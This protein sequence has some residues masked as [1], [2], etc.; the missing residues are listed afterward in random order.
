M[1]EKNHNNTIRRSPAKILQEQETD[2]ESQKT[3]RGTNPESK[4]E[5][6][7]N[8]SLVLSGCISLPLFEYEQR[9]ET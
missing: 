2:R 6:S 3:E 8:F 4:Q 9:I 5:Q 1:L 7:R